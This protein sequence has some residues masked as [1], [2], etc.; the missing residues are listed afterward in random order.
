M[1]ITF[2]GKVLRDDKIITIET[3][4][5]KEKPKIISNTIPKFIQDNKGTW[6]K[7][8]EWSDT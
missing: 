2:S 1:K 6:I 8:P 7:N 3:E 5:K 4:E